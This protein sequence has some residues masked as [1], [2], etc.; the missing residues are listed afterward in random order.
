MHLKKRLFHLLVILVRG[1]YR[2]VY[3]VQVVGLDKLPRSGRII[4]ATNHISLHDPILLSAFLD[5]GIRFMAKEELFR[6]PVLRNMIRRLPRPP[7]Q[8]LPRGNSTFDT[9]LKQF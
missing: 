4:L 6:I 9:S 1:F 2:R 5:P 7:C 3:R 8:L